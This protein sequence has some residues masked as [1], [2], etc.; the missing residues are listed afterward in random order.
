MSLCSSAT[1]RARRARAAR[2]VLVAGLALAGRG[3]PALFAADVRPSP[4]F[5]G[6]MSV[7]GA[8][9]E[10]TVT[11]VSH[12]YSA[13]AGPRTRTTLSGVRAHVGHAPETVVLDTYGGPLPDGT[14]AAIAGEPQFL[15][16]KRYLVFLTNRPWRYS[17]V[18]RQLAFRVE[19]VG[20]KPLL[21]ADDGRPARGV[22]A[23][24]VVFG[25]TPLFE[26]VSPAETQAPARKAVPVEAAG[27]APSV[28]EFV[29]G[30]KKSFPEL[31]RGD[32][33]PRLV[34]QRLATA[35]ANAA[36][37][38]PSEPDPTAPKGR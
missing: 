26:R 24:G 1:C 21:I 2:M 11:A 32:R 31:T 27:D 37:T 4:D 12:G 33:Q 13:S 36:S 34:P 5:A 3:A 14:Y 8:V 19:D 28:S 22:N 18:T 15:S 20:G 38:A 23:K 25:S 6:A 29:A 17:P 30:L 10:G 9:V 7:T 16:G 35:A